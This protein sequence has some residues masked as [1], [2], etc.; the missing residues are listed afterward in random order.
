MVYCTKSVYLY[1]VQVNIQVWKCLFLSL[2]TDPMKHSL[3]SI[4][5]WWPIGTSLLC[6]HTTQAQ[7]HT[8]ND[9][10][11]PLLVVTVIANH[12]WDTL[13][14]CICHQLSVKIFG[15]IPHTLFFYRLRFSVITLMHLDADLWHGF[16]VLARL[17]H[18]PYPQ[19][20]FSSF[21]QSTVKFC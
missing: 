7:Y 8:Y 6:S 11:I 16:L 18:H 12:I 20:N 10:Q 14:C 5:V 17:L 9:H 19:H 1:M 4:L 13:L 15:D 3:L 21:Q 2:P